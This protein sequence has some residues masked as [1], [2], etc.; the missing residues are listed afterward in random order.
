MNDILFTFDRNTTYTQS[1]RTFWLKRNRIAVKNSLI[2]VN[3]YIFQVKLQL[4]AKYT[5]N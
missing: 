3:L 4:I 1:S 2:H 5:I